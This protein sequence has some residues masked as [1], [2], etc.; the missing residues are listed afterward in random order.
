M[1]LVHHFVVVDVEHGELVVAAAVVS[2]IIE[3]DLDEQ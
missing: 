1:E 2:D 3:H